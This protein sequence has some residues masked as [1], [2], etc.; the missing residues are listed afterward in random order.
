MGWRAGFR[1]TAAI[2]FGTALL[3]LLLV[4]KAPEDMGLEPYRKAGAAESAAKSAAASGWAGLSRGEA[5]KT[6]AFWLYALCLVCCGIVAAG[7]ATQIPTYLIENG[8][9]YAPVFAVYSGVGIV[10]KLVVGPIIDKLGLGRGSV[11]TAVIGVVALVFLVLVPALGEW[12]SYASMIILP[13]GSAITALAPPLLTGM[14]FGHRDFGP[15][16]GLGNTAFMAGCM[17]GPMLTSGLRDALGSYQVAWYACMAA[18]ALIAVCTFTALSSSKK[19][20]A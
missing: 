13:F 14:C 2:V 15:I 9:D 19:L 11:I 3:V 18:Y 5:V 12:S 8:I 10:A 16:Y 1:V 6:G 20:R 17:I 4:R 7:V